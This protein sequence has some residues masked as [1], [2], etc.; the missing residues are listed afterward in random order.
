MS[1]SQQ[2]AA[3]GTCHTGNSVKRQNLKQ[4]THRGEKSMLTMGGISVHTELSYFNSM[5]L[6]RSLF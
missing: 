5:G 2:Y 4:I 1:E 3:A 6:E